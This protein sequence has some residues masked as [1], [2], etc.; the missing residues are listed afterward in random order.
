MLHQKEM[1]GKGTDSYFK[2]FFPNASFEAFSEAVL[3]KGSLALKS[4][5]RFPARNHFSVRNEQL[6]QHQI[7]VVLVRQNGG[8]RPQAR[9]ACF[10]LF[11]F[12]FLLRF[13]I[14]RNAT[15]CAFI[16]LVVLEYKRFCC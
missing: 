1:L 11:P 15:Y 5:N 8:P 7:A 2:P 13:S 6:R 3:S 14:P 10:P 12:R 4:L 16:F 9:C